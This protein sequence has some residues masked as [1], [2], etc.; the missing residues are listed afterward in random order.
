MNNQTIGLI[1]T[2]FLAALV[3]VGYIVLTGLERDTSGLLELAGGLGI[4][5]LAQGAALLKPGAGSSG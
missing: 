2:T 3:V 5:T 4:A 1:C